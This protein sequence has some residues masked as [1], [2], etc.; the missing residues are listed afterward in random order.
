MLDRVSAMAEESQA[1][2]PNA[3]NWEIFTIE[4]E[5]NQ[6]PRT[7][8]GKNKERIRRNGENREMTYGNN[9]KTVHTLPSTFL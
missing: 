8:T 1:L 5:D 2:I 3:R 7:G 9:N 4:F 6:P